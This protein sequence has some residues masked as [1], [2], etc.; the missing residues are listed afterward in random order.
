[1]HSIK[2]V[3]KFYL[4][5]LFCLMNMALSSQNKSYYTH[6]NFG[7]YYEEFANQQDLIDFLEIKNKDVVADIGTDNGFIMTALSLLYDSVTFYAEDTDPKRLNQKHFDKSV[8]YFTKLR[9]KPQTNQ[10]RFSIGTYTSTNLPNNTFDK[11]LM[12]ASFHEFT[13]MDSMLIDFKRKLKPTGKIYILEAFS[14]IDKTIYCDDHHKGYRIDEVITILQKHGFYLTKMRSPE[15]NIISYANCLVFER[16]PSKS[17]TFNTT[18]KKIKPLIDKTIL[19]NNQIVAA[20]SVSMMLKTDS[21]KMDIQNIS[22]VYSAY[23]CWIRDIGIKWMAQ[24]NYLPAINVF[25]SL[26]DLYPHSFQNQF[27]LAKAYEAN[28]QTNFALISYKKALQLNPSDKKLAKKIKKIQ[29][30]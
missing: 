19:F 29:K 2:Y 16:N 8:N 3:I 18:Q 11:I 17:V 9:S 22:T 14:L 20:D 6:K 24:K 1:M 13:F 21:I 25:K 30:D 15:S 7:T 10:F 28:K 12:A 26:C 23:E 4:I 27:N 5:L